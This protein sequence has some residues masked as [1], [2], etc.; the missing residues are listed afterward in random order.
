MTTTNPSLFCFLCGNE[1]TENQI[2]ADYMNQKVHLDCVHD[3]TC[4][5]EEMERL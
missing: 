1:I 5:H 2:D 3:I 4:T